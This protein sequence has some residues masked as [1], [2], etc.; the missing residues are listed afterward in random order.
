[1][2]TDILVVDDEQDIRELVAGILEDE[3]HG[4]RMAGDASRGVVDRDLRVFGKSNLYVGGSSV[5]TTGCGSTNPTLSIVAFALRLAAR[6]R[7][8]TPA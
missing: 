7:D 8:G 4:T 1:M 6:L 3:G 5:W 2:A